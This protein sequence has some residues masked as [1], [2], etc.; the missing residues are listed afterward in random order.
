MQRDD[1]LD[2]VHL[3]EKWF[4]L[5]QERRRFYLVPGECKPD[6]SCKNK[7]YIT[8]VMF[9]SA[10]AR[11]QYIDDTDTWWD[12]KIGTVNRPAGAPEIKSVSVIRDVYRS[13]LI[14]N[15][16]PAN[17][18]KLPNA[19]K[20]VKLQQDNAP[21]HVPINDLAINAVFNTYAS[22]GW[23]SSLLPQPPIRPT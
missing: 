9:L 19:K 12:G 14:E 8:R 6:R 15:V 7:R 11:P 22:S 13:F 1:M 5:T 20:I 4:Y 23:Q 17:L 16:L 3:D 18:D 21:A 10:V 2:C